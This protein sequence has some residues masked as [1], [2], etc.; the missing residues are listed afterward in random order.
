MKT[1]SLKPVSKQANE[2]TLSFL[3]LIAAGRLAEAEKILINNPILRETALKYLPGLRHTTF[4]KER[5]RFYR[6][7]AKKNKMVSR[8]RGEDR[9]RLRDEFAASHCKTLALKKAAED[10]ANRIRQ[11][12]QYTCEA[13]MS[14][15]KQLKIVIR[16][17][18][19]KN[20]GLFL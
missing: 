3:E 2:K 9:Q 11:T 5:I 10:A 13:T 7:F 6:N 20:R 19:L 15:F 17:R 18:Q 16:R 4:F 12:C 14:Q 1:K 8:L